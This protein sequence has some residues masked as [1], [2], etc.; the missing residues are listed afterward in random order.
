MSKTLLEISALSLI[1]ENF[2]NDVEMISFA[3]TELMPPPYSDNE[4]EIEIDKDDAIEMIKI[5]KKHFKLT[6]EDLK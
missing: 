6:E 4:V 2:G 3:W 5:F 1:Y